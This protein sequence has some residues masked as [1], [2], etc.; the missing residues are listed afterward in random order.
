MALSCPRIKEL[1]DTFS[2]QRRLLLRGVN[3]EALEQL[4]T[5]MYI[6][7]IHITDSNAHVMFTRYYCIINKK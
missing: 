3:A 2:D 7:E 4:I 5:F 6:G 1:L